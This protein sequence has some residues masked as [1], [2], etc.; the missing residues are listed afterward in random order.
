VV[1]KDLR[2]PMLVQE[3]TS[4]L[5][6]ES[7]TNSAGPDNPGGSSD[8]KKVYEDVRHCECAVRAG[9]GYAPVCAG[10]GGVQARPPCLPVEPNLPKEVLHVKA[11]QSRQLPAY[12]LHDIPSG[13][14]RVDSVT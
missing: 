2:T 7:G 4:A 9:I 10:G 8:E 13:V 11:G 12:T 1:L 6:F 3:R 5:Q 14:R